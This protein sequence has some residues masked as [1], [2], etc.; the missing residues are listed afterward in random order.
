MPTT[1]DLREDGNFHVVKLV[2]PTPLTAKFDYSEADAVIYA[3]N[4]LFGILIKAGDRVIPGT[5]K[6]KGSI[7]YQAC[8]E[9]SCLAPESIGFD[10]EITVADFDQETHLANADIFSTIDFKK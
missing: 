8:N 5:Y 10:L 7:M 6:L 2:Y 3:G 1:V 4:V 9:R